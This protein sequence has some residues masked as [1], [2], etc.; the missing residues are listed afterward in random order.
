M[1]LTIR[2]D[3]PTTFGGID[4]SA[5]A[6]MDLTAIAAHAPAEIIHEMVQ[7]TLPEL[8]ITDGSGPGS[9]PRELDRDRHRRERPARAARKPAVSGGSSVRAA[10]RRPGTQIVWIMRL[11]IGD[12]DT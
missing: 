10:R 3:A 11:P 12:C 8:C 4:G 5:R 2:W 1:L 6:I 7:F 9:R